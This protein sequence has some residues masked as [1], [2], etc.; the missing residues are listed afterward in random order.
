M[1]FSS[2]KFSL[3]ALGVT[4]IVGSRTLFF[5][6]DDVEGPNLLVVMVAAAIIYLFSL[7]AYRLNS[8]DSS[9]AFWLAIFTQIIVITSL[10]F[11]GL[12]F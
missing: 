2:K 6:F 11:L 12:K 10:Y 1:L 7:M 9:K 3:I 8:S 5:L 4:A